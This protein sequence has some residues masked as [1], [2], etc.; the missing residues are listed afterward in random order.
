MASTSGRKALAIIAILTGLLAVSGGTGHAS[1]GYL[2]SFNTQY[3]TSATRLNTCTLCHTSV[4]ALNPYGSAYAAAGHSFTAIEGADSDGDGF[5]N[6]AEIQALTFPGNAADKPAPPAGSPALSITPTADAFGSV[7]VGLASSPVVNTLSN[8]GTAALSVTGM[9]L[10]DTA[11]YALNLN[12]GTAPCGAASTSLAPGASC[13]VAVT[14]SPKAAGS[15]P[16]SLTVASND[17]LGADVVPLTGTGVAAAVPKASV[18]PATIAFGTVTVGGSS[19]PAVST[20]ANTGTA[21]LSI[22]AMSLSN[23]TDF[24][25]NLNGGTNP[26]GTAAKSLAAGASCTVATTF[27]PKSSGAR[28]ANLAV[29]SNDPATPTATV[30]MTGTG[31]TAAAP[32]IAASPASMAMGS[33][34]LGASSAPQTLTV[35]NT[36]NANLSIGTLSLGGANASEFGLQN[37]RCSAQTLA[38]AATCT[39]QVVFTPASAAAK[40]GMLTVPSNDAATPALGVSL[41]GTGASQ[42][43]TAPSI[44]STSPVDNASNVPLNATVSATFSETMAAASLTTSTFR[45]FANGIPVAGSVSLS[46]TTATYTPS[47]PLAAGTRHTATVTTGASDLGGTGIAAARSWSFTTVSPI[48]NTDSDGDGVMDADDD[49]PND[50]RKA[51]PRPHHGHGKLRLDI[52]SILGAYLTEVHAMSETGY[53]NRPAGYHFNDGMISFKINRG[54][55]AAMVTLTFD[56][57]IPAGSKVYMVDHGEFRAVPGA[58]VTGNTVTL[59]VSAASSG[60]ATS[61]ALTMGGTDTATANVVGVASPD[62]AP[63]A[64]TS[65]GGCSA[66]RTGA[67]QGHVDAGMAFLVLA[68]FWMLAR[69][70]LRAVRK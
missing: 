49:Y 5:T 14:F 28:T 4:P 48:D 6:L 7:T 53:D 22:S 16:A 29:A 42:A 12:G 43:P 21:A 44:V 67:G 61:Q 17:P 11:N 32:R 2:S 3:G 56:D 10:S 55:G 25:L 40:A 8:N 54:S 46:G 47:A 9:T 63:A 24:T 20:I 60:S 34:T 57:A 30:A 65:G 51:T 50:N 38:P 36:G 1:S 15:L 66:V 62:A 27:N 23:T 39:V 19:A 41:S 33:V 52:S 35:S 18:T 26:C 13:T 45:L 31:A 68:G 70:M 58:V 69:R 37:D 59:P 64:A